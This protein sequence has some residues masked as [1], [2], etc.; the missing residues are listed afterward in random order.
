LEAHVSKTQTGLTRLKMRMGWV[1]IIPV[2]KPY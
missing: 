1:T 2:W